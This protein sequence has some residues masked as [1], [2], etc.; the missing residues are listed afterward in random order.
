MPTGLSLG[1]RRADRVEHFER[2]AH[3]VLQASRHIDRCAGWRSATGTDAG[4]SRARSA[5]RCASMPSRSAR[6]AA[7]TKASRTRASPA[8]SSA[9]GGASPSL[10][11]TADGPSGL[12]AA[13]GQRDQLAAVPRRV[14]R[15]LAA[16]MRELHRHRGLRMLA[17]RGEDRL[18]RGFGGVVP[19]AEAARRDAADR[20][21]RGGLDAEHRRARQRQRVDV[22][23]VP[24]IGLA[25]DR[26]NTGTSAPP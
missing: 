26:P 14:A 22:G 1:K 6:F 17:H 5:A 21:H 11:G 9:S 3:A 16:G 4:D 2:I 15:C 20:L 25:I 24:V 18:Q 23:E 10:C 12:P 7:A 8:A 19:Q 13:F